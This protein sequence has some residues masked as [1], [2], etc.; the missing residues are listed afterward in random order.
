MTD[1]PQLAEPRSILIELAGNAIDNLANSLYYSLT[2][3]VWETVMDRWTFTFVAMLVV[4]IG[5]TGFARSHTNIQVALDDP[6]KTAWPAFTIE[7]P[8]TP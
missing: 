7:R 8:V 3:L 6:A 5:F 4:S 1:F 2:H